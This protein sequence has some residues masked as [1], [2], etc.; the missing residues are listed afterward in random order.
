MKAILGILILFLSL[1][2]IST[3]SY[4]TQSIQYPRPFFEAFYDT[5]LRIDYIHSGNSDTEHFSIARYITEGAWG[6]KTAHPIDSLT[7][8][9]YFLEISDYQTGKLLYSQGFNSVFGEWQ[10]TQEAQNITREFHESIRIPYPQRIVTITLKKRDTQNIL[11]P[12]WQFRLDPTKILTSP[13]QVSPSTKITTLIRNGEPKVKAD[14]AILG[15]GYSIADSARFAADA[16]HFIRAFFGTEPFKSRKA[17]F[18]VYAIFSPSPH[19]GIAKERVDFNPGNILGTSFYT[20]G[21]ERYVLVKD[22]WIVR[23]FAGAVPYDFTV[24]LLNTAKYGGGGIYNLYI[25]TA[26]SIPQADY[27]MVHEMGHHIA[28]LADEYY[29]SEVAYA[30]ANTSVEPWELNVTALLCPDSLKWRELV[31]A[32]TPIP[33]PWDKKAYE[34][35]QADVIYNPDMQGVVGAYEGANYLS[36]GMFRP[37]V[38]CIMFSRTQRFCKVCT[39]SLNKVLN[40]YCQ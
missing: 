38:N 30:P 16:N 25:T 7:L 24:I 27:V 28:G 33:T 15:D 32:G 35:G 3:G 4:T 5:T 2:T 29:T 6:G 18:N 37:E 1:S 40:Q 20:F 26:T 19:S 34:S 39:E 23:Q 12:I 9:L 31:S 10:T 36:K 14:I 11:K 22:D 8:G 21:I 17:D 13:N